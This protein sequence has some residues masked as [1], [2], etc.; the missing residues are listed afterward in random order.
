METKVRHNLN[1]IQ[2]RIGG[3]VLPM[4]PQLAAKT[5]PQD[6]SILEQAE[7]IE[8]RRN[9]VRFAVLS[10]LREAALP[11]EADP[12]QPLHALFAWTPRCL[13]TTIAESF[14]AGTTLMPYAALAYRQVKPLLW[15]TQSRGSGMGTLADT[16]FSVVQCVGGLV[17]AV[18]RAHHLDPGEFD[19]AL[20]AIENVTR[21]AWR[22]PNPSS[23]HMIVEE[24]ARKADR[25]RTFAIIAALVVFAAAV[26]VVVANQQL[27]GK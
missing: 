10:G 17:V 27:P 5:G 9:G 6:R 25:N 2:A 20:T 24:N 8:F 19:R 12:S 15:R 21:L 13:A 4:G 18:S 16:S 11:A 23:F 3:S 7:A 1:A 14:E 26:A 22:G